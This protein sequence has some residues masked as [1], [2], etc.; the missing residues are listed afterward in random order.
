MANDFPNWTHRCHWHSSSTLPIRQIQC[1]S[2]NAL[3]L[4]CCRCCIQLEIRDEYKKYDGDDA[5][6]ALAFDSISKT[7]PCFWM[8]F[9]CGLRT[10]KHK[11]YLYRE[12]YINLIRFDLFVVYIRFFFSFKLFCCQLT[13]FSL[14]HSFRLFYRCSCIFLGGSF[15]LFFAR[16]FFVAFCVFCVHFFKNNYTMRLFIAQIEY[17]HNSWYFLYIFCSLHSVLWWLLWCTSSLFVKFKYNKKN[18]DARAV[19]QKSTKANLFMQSK[20]IA[21]AVITFFTSFYS[22][23][24]NTNCPWVWFHQKN[25]IMTFSTKNWIRTANNSIKPKFMFRQMRARQKRVKTFFFFLVGI[26]KRK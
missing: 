13:I 7:F 19:Q 26:F 21:I 1:A 15:S 20:F 18:Q 25:R 2:I 8:W 9:L 24:E 23:A 17:F 16:S 10:T 5:I 14:F 12:I 22:F 6:D 11:I 3:H 4:V